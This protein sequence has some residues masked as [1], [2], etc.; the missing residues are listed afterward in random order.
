MCAP[1]VDSPGE[2]VHIKPY[3]LPDLGDISPSLA[4]GMLGMPG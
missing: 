2:R 3:K 4:V 1:D